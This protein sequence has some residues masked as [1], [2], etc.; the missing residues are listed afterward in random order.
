MI[1]SSYFTIKWNN[2]TP[3]NMHGYF[4]WFEMMWEIIWFSSWCCIWNNKCKKVNNKI[5]QLLTPVLGNYYLFMTVICTTK[6]NEDLLATEFFK[7][8]YIES[9]SSL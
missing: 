8:K 1:Y 9:N 2:K 6:L 4:W 7:S 3:K 5:I